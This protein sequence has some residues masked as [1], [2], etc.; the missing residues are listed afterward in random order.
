MHRSIFS[1]AAAVLALALTPGCSADEEEA[2]DEAVLEEPVEEG[3]EE[4]K[5]AL[6]RGNIEVVQ[7]NIYFG[8]GYSVV[9]MSGPGACNDPRT[10]STANEFVERIARRKTAGVIGMQEVRYESEAWYLAT[11]LSQQT[12]QAWSYV[13][14]PEKGTPKGAASWG[15]AILYRSGFLKLVHAFEPITVEDDVKRVGSTR[16]TNLIFGG[17]LFKNPASKRSFTIWTGKLL[18]PGQWQVGKNVLDNAEDSARR[19]V[20]VERLV[21]G[22]DTKLDQ[23]HAPKNTTRIITLDMNDGFTSKA[24][25]KFNALGFEDGNDASPTWPSGAWHT[26]GKCAANQLERQTPSRR[27][28]YVFWDSRTENARKTSHR[29][30]PNPRVSDNYGSDHRYVAVDVPVLDP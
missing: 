23:I 1:L 30:L 11:R 20:E 14:V 8:G 9:S 29:A 13:Y 28:D 15:V 19:A 10:A 5:S 26:D 7:S 17:A 4:L 24:R 18:P 25:A 2:D 27:F 3:A 6:A 22:I 12:H 21:R 16:G